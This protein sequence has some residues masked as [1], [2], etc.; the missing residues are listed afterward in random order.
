M[1]ISTITVLCKLNEFK[2]K[3][4]VTKSGSVFTRQE[5]FADSYRSLTTLKSEGEQKAESNGPSDRITLQKK[6]VSV[7]L[8]RTIWKIGIEHW[9]NV[10]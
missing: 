2:L 3:N 10:L 1:L 7:V 6:G 4:K 8:V 5:D 9:K